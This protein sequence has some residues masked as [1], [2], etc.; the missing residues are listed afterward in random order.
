MKKIIIIATSLLLL[1][2][3]VQASLVSRPISKFAA[4]GYWQAFGRGALK[5]PAMPTQAVPQSSFQQTF[6]QLPSREFSQAS[7]MKFPAQKSFA[8]SQ[9]QNYQD[10]LSQRRSMEERPWME[11]GGAGADITTTMGQPQTVEQVKKNLFEGLYRRNALQVIENTAAATEFM[12]NGDISIPEIELIEEAARRQIDLIDSGI[13]IMLGGAAGVTGAF[14]GALMGL[15]GAAIGVLGSIGFN[16]M[17]LAIL[18]V[19]LGNFKASADLLLK[20]TAAAKKQ[21]QEQQEQEA[22]N[23]KTVLDYYEDLD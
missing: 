14:G 17:Y 9:Q 10:I 18:K 16:S 21:L 23:P 5:T 1:A 2:P 13:T 20:V 19:F 12:L 3:Q 15:P 6:G 4:P 8:M 11:F 22:K 7:G